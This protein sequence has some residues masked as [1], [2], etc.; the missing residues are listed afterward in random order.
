M[1]NVAEG[2]TTARSLHEWANRR[3]VEMPIAAEVYRI[4]FEGKSPLAAV[5]ALMER[6][7][8]DEW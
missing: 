4:L 8:K 2:V 3:G 1:A 5:S 6:D 7:P